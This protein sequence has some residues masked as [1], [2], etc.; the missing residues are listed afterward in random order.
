[1]IDKIII[2]PNNFEEIQKLKN[3]GIT[4]FLLPLK[5]YSI[6]YSNFDI[7]VINKIEDPIYLLINRILTSF[8]IENMLDIINKLNNV[9]GIFYEDLGVF[10]QLKK[11]K[12]EL[13][14]YQTHFN[15]HYQVIDYL[16]ELGNNSVVVANDLTYDEIKF[17]IN[18]SVNKLCLFLFGRSEVMYSRRLLK[19]NYLKKYNLQKMNSVIIEEV[20]GVKFNLEENKYGTFLFSNYFYNGLDLLNL[21]Q[22]KIKFYIISCKDLLIDKIILILTS[23]KDNNLSNINLFNIEMDK[24]FLEKETI[25]QL[26]AG[27]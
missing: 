25:Y 9:K 23:L 6:G 16:C 14:N 20:S 11:S 4:T 7:D 10:Y 21:N 18:N 17:V 12:Y 1:M 27:E 15:T 24:G 2:I 5:E 19:S 22:E 26:K 3:V 13:I 8:E